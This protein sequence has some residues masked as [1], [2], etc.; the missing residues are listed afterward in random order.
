MF[1]ADLRWFVANRKKLKMICETESAGPD[2]RGPDLDHI[3][4]DFYMIKGPGQ[5]RF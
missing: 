3:Q 1:T 5:R 2:S 4:Y